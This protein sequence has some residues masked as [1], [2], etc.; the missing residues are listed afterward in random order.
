[1]AGTAA[2]QIKGFGDFP[3]VQGIVIY[4]LTAVIAMKFNHGKREGEM[5]V[6]EAFQGPFM[7]F[8]A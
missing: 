5:D 3:P 4:K 2:G 1:M 6:L 7:R 8:I